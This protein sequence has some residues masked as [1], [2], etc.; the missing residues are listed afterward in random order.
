VRRPNQDPSAFAWLLAF[1]S[2]LLPW[3]ATVLGLVGIWL[4]AR[5]EPGVWY[6]AIAGLLLIADALID[7]VWAHPA[8]LPTDQPDLNLR[9]V[10]LIGRVLVV[11]E[12]I[13][14]GGGKARLGDTLWNVEGADAPAGAQVRVLEAKGSVLRVERV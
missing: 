11:E 1:V 10:Q 2:L 7:L 3:A 9:A 6:L 8:A 4:I 5:G 13:V 14:H 12:P